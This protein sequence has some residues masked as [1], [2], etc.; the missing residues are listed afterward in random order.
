MV[1]QPADGAEVPGDGRRCLW[2]EERCFCFALA[3]WRNAE[4][5]RATGWRIKRLEKTTYL[6]EP[7]FWSLMVSPVT[8]K[9]APAASCPIACTP[10]DTLLRATHVSRSGTWVYKKIPLSNT[11]IVMKVM[12]SRDELCR[13]LFT[14]VLLYR[15]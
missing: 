3:T 9:N 8:Q 5:G 1:H 14:W 6:S 10:P 11:R 13:H 15:K 7:F 12:K 4:V 2:P